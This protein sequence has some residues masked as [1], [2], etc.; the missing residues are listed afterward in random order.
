[1]DASCLLA[2]GRDWG[3]PSARLLHEPESGS[4]IHPASPTP[5]PPPQTRDRAVTRHAEGVAWDS[6]GRGGRCV[7]LG[8][9]GR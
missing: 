6:P 4:G 8:G 7:S 1:M 3:V 9:E 5:N 2:W